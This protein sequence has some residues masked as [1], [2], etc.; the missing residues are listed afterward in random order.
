MKT[1]KIY[2]T[3][4]LL[5]ITGCTLSPKE[6]GGNIQYDVFYTK[7]FAPLQIQE[8]STKYRY[9]SIE[10]N[11]N[12][13]IG[14]IKTPIMRKNDNYYIDDQSCIFIFDR[15]GKHLKTFDRQGQG[16]GE[17]GLYF[18]STVNDKGDIAL[19]TGG[20]KIIYNYSSEGDF[21]SKI[22]LDS[23]HTDGI[24]FINDTLLLLHDI[25]R[26]DGYKY[27]VLN[28]LSQQVQNTFY[29]MKYRKHYSMRRDCLTS[30]DGKIQVSQY[31]SNE[32][33][34]ITKDSAYVKYILNINNKMPPEGYW[35][36]STSDIFDYRNKGYIGDIECFAEGKKDI[37]F[38]FRGIGE[39]RQGFALIEK[40]TGLYIVFEELILA[41]GLSIKPSYFHSLG[42]GKICFLINPIQILE[43]GN[44][45]FIAQFPNLEEDSNPV[46]LEIELE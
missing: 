39:E 29:P 5:L 35:E 19:L 38:R 28:L 7:P 33:L 42:E 32:I 21:V 31:Q 24:A 46:L 11:K 40:K 36:E 30:N 10:T 22:S 23:L 41:E 6:T 27:H 4:I 13:L 2:W 14:E 44:N 12:S 18:C 34:E 37:L 43:S 15:N 17:Y 3:S 25:E 16:P 1:S 9:I 8:V 20:S 26:T 45:N